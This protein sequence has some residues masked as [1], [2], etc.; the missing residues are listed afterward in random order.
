MKT[1]IRKLCPSLAITAAVLAATPLL[2]QESR[3][4][5]PSEA[6]AATGPTT[7]SLE[8]HCAQIVRTAEH[9]WSDTD[10]VSDYRQVHQRQLQ[11]D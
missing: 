5:A 11:G 9:L 4:P 2:A 7:L 6:K 10:K 8:K 1:M 3:S